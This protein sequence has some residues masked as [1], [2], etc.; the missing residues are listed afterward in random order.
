MASMYND[1]SIR[2]G[3]EFYS[4]RQ[5]QKTSS[6]EPGR[7]LEVGKASEIKNS[8][9]M[10]CREQATMFDRKIRFLRFTRKASESNLMLRV[11][12]AQGVSYD[13]PVSTNWAMEALQ[14]LLS[15]KT[16]KID[17]D[18]SP[19][20]YKKLLNANLSENQPDETPVIKTEPETDFFP[21]IFPEIRFDPLFSE[22][23]TEPNQLFDDWVEPSN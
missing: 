9:T 21:D 12:D 19:G 13:G 7:L 22:I 20:K 14:S 3:V 23:K 18:A 11:R 1:E 8:S 2:L 17:A 6:Q 15:D 5:G 10:S 16:L 4:I